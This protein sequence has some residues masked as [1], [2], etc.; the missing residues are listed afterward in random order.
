MCAALALGAPA[1][2]GAGPNTRYD[3]VATESPDPVDPSDLSECP[4]N[5]AG[6]AR[7]QCIYSRFAERLSD[8]ADVT[9]DGI[10]D[11]FASTWIQDLPPS[12]VGGVKNNNAG[13]ISLINGATQKVVYK[14]T[15]EPQVDGNFGFYISVPGDVGPNRDGKED[16]VSG[17][18]GYDVGTGPGGAGCT[19]PA[20]PEPNQCNENQGRG[21]VISGPTGQ[22]IATLDNFNPQAN[23]GFSSRLGAAGDVNGDGVQDILAAAPSN[24]F[25]AGCANVP[26]AQRPANCS[27]NEGEVFVVNGAD[28]TLIRSL[29][30]PAADRRPLP[31]NSACG[32]LGGG[33]Q[34]VGDVNGDK[35]PDHQVPATSYTPTPA[36][37]VA[38]TYSAGPTGMSSR[39]STSRPRIR[40]ASLDSWT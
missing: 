9:G 39:G 28:F 8:A 19:R 38:S 3:V 30:I 31:C 20:T 37:T 12:E 21:Y 23:G 24:D 16:L 10:R 32:G 4:M 34:N 17:A 40:T 27:A 33:P 26:V 36:A 29:R 35:V 1:A 22:R 7:P 5:Q 11:V 6:T 13:R 15:P 25:P 14:V 2:L 18:S